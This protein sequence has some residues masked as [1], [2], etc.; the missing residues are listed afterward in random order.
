MMTI[1]GLTINIIKKD[2]Y[3]HLMRPFNVHKNFQFD[4]E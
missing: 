4:D 1:L 3:D 2:V